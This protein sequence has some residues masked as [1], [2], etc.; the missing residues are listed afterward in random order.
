LLGIV[1]WQKALTSPDV[2]RPTS[3]R[4]TSG[5]K[6]DIDID[7]T[8]KDISLVIQRTE[9]E[10]LQEAK[11][12]EGDLIFEA[13][14]FYGHGAD[15]K[16]DIEEMIEN[17]KEEY[18]R[19]ELGRKMHELREAEEAKDPQKS[20]QILAECQIINNKIQDIKNNKNS[21]PSPVVGQPGV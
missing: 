5:E 17:L 20:A 8:M 10:I 14:V 16:K 18:L 13:E 12:D 21:R 7:K 1:L 3:G 6:S 15:L 9:T 11:K 2:G 19:E 4:P